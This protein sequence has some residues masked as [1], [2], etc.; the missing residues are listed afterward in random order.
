MAGY[1]TTAAANA[2][3][4]GTPMP[5]TFYAAGRLADPGVDGSANHAAET[6]RI[7]V[8]MAAPSAGAAANSNSGTVANAAASED[9][10]HVVLYDASSGGTAWW[11]VPFA[12][13]VSITAGRTIRFAPGALVLGLTLWS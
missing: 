6:R 3:L 10:S 12:V 11:V 13:P 1:L 7:T 2:V 8:A 5:T 9:W 4:A